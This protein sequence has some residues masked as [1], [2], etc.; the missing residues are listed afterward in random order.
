MSMSFTTGALVGAAVLAGAGA[1]A[2][3]QGL[4]GNGGAEV[5]HARALT[6]TVKTPREACHDE[7]VTHTRAVKDD[8]RLVGT[9]LGAVVG[10]ILGNQ[11]GGGNGKKL[12]TVAGA[13]AGG[14]AGNQIQGRVQQADTYTTTERRCETVYDRSEEADGFEVVYVLN[15]KQH[16]VHMDHDPGRRLPIKDGHVV[17]AES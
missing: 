11:V 8:H 6:R 7:Q 9:G 4:L 15:G 10:G 14:F 17:T 16:T 3:Y 5:V 1:V 12:A 13:A 2:G